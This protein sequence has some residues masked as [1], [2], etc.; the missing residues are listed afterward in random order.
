MKIPYIKKWTPGKI[1]KL[2]KF[3]LIDLI[4][5]ASKIH[6]K[7][8]KSNEVQISTL[9]SIK[10][11]GCPEDCGYCPQASRYNTNIDKNEL[12]NINKVKAQA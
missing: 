6:R 3:P 7:H 5:E 4:Y 12:M 9:I 2:F 8:H 1:E 11:G 10:T